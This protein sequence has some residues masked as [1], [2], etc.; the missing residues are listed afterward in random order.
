M[1]LTQ[2]RYV[3]VCQQLLALGAVLAVLVPA[4]CVVSLDVVVQRPGGAQVASLAAAGS[5][6]GEPARVP[7][8][9]VA[10]EVREYALTS[11]ASAAAPQ[12]SLRRLAG[13]GAE[14]V[15]RPET[16]RGY[17]TV[18]LTWSPT[19]EEYADGEIEVTLRTRTG[20]RTGETWSP[21]T[22]VPYDAEHGPDPGSD[23]ALHQRP[24]TDP[25][26]V[27]AVD[28]VQ[29][30]VR[31]S[32]GVP[33]DVRLAV[34]EPGQAAATEVEEP[35]I[36]TATLDG[37]AEPTGLLSGLRLRAVITS[38]PQIFSRA[39]WG[40]DESLRDASS[41][42]YYEVH[43]GFVH[44]TVNANDYTRDEVPGIIRS[45][46]AY[47][48][49]SK[50]WSDIGYNFL[51]D[52]FGRIWEGR[53][54]GVDRPVVGAHTLNYND[55]SFAMSAI[56]NYEIGQP[57]AAVLDAY[58]RLFAWKLS[59]H[60]VDAGSTR[61]KVGSDYFQAING[62]RDAGETACPGKYLYAKLPTI[63]SL[64]DR[65]QSAWAGRE[66]DVDSVSTAHP[67]I[68]LRRSSDKAGFVLPTR[69]LLRLGWPRVA[70]A[71][72]WSAKDAI[73]ATS[74]V[75]GDG[76]ADVLARDKATGTARI[77]PGDGKGHFAAGIKPTSIFKGFDQITAVGDLD[78]D[79]RRDFVGRNPD[80]GWLRLFHGTGGGGFKGEMWS[81][82]W[83]SYDKTAGV[84]D[85]TGDGL[86]DL[87]ARD[88][89]GRLW[90]YPGRGRSGLGARVQLGG[91][92]SSYDVITGFGD[93]TGDRRP[94]LFVRNASSGS[95]YVFPNK[96]N[97]Q[98]G[99]WLGPLP[100]VTGVGAVSSAS[101]VGGPRP[102][103]VG[104]KGDA[105]VTLANADT[106]NTSA[107]VPLGARLSTATM[108]LS[109]GDW[110]RD[111]DGDLM[112]RTGAGELQLRLSDGNGHFATPK[113]ISSAF[114]A[115]GLLSA[116]GDLTGD[117]YPD[118]M[119][120][121]SGGAMRIYPGRGAAGLGVGYVAHAGIS[122]TRQYGVG[123]W[124]SD[125][126]P[127]NLLRVDDRLVLYP[128]NGPGGLT[129]PVSLGVDVSAYDWVLGVGD[130]NGGHADL[131]AREK[132][133]GYL[134]LLPGT[135]S[136]VGQRIFLAEGLGGYDLAG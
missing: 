112:T 77:H 18:G 95:S 41:L 100:S 92:W 72:G 135:T 108:L 69:G 33:D 117:G 6:V 36:D 61:Q 38:K 43:A 62:H 123:L 12:V 125:G 66:R 88:T 127:D 55:Y 81:K 67:D 71:T 89:S 51:V 118:L 26:V 1:R 19:G 104:R 21:W 84:G 82:S 132:A 9:A 45:I 75:T 113:T 73:V 126:S 2:A 80:T 28:Q 99:H 27:G 44:H 58:G 90:L 8:S 16:V 111:G 105:L 134:W 10:P 131:V 110:D 94:D 4:A 86:P 96:G 31:T 116:V 37:E 35:A 102:D 107:P 122:A 128:G 83:A 7:V 133:T 120:Q 103:L 14:L 47:H 57:S 50:G 40:A 136:G 46:Y 119:G 52:R 3:T 13:G 64:A 56:G 130:L 97:R 34:V 23:E 29:V 25:V 129:S 87:V 20:S 115:V 124:N 53:Y 11:P 5:G 91:S 106:Y 22:V 70:G 63:R 98:V 121:P 17:G 49:Q 42:H 109:V 74:D 59:L 54:G 93:Y 101:V 30:R 39:Q 65:Y 85:F 60:G 79:G 24:G 68:F 32:S 48:T 114:A 78:H 15:S 76:L